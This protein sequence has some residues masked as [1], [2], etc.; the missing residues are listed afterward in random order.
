M[1]PKKS[2]KSRY[3]LKTINSSAYG[4]ININSTEIGTKINNNQGYI[5]AP[6][7]MVDSTPL[8]SEIELAKMKQELRLKKLKRLMED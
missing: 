5:Y 3:L 4:R 7:I 6:Y 2:I 1:I 8:M